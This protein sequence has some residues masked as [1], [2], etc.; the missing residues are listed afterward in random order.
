MVVSSLGNGSVTYCA[1]AEKEN[2]MKRQRRRGIMTAILRHKTV[3]LIT[4]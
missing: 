3:G 1:R 2:R 4:Q